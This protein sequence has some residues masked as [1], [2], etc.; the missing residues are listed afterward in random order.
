MNF[1]KTLKK[2]DSIKNIYYRCAN[3]R[4]IITIFSLLAI[5]CFGDALPYNTS[6]GTF[7]AASSISS[8]FNAFNWKW[9]DYDQQ[10]ID[11]YFTGVYTNGNIS[12]AMAY[13]KYGEQYLLV[14][15]GTTTT[16]GTNTRHIADIATSNIPPNNSYFSEFL[17]THTNGQTRS[18]A[19]GKIQTQWSVY[20]ATNA[21]NWSNVVVS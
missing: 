20:D 19:K 1:S 14:I 2:I 15:N 13:P 6:T 9:S 17:F 7:T 10:R 21:A 11:V 12:F 4:Y 5:T 3:M 18:L 16:D 8:D